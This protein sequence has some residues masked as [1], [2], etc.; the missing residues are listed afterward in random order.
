[1]ALSKENKDYLDEFGHGPG[2]N[3]EFIG[4]LKNI[5]TDA[6]ISKIKLE[7]KAKQVTKLTIRKNEI[8]SK[9]AELEK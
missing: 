3:K 7:L 4:A 2:S 6:D 8:I 5:L 1:M 9:L